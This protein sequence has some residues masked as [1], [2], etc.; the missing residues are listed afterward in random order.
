[1]EE[2][3]FVE[4]PQ[5]EYVEVEENFKVKD[6]NEVI[7]EL[8]VSAE[9][10][11]V[12]G[13]I[14]E[15][16]E[17]INQ[18]LKIGSLTAYVVLGQYYESK[19]E[20][21]KAQETYFQGYVANS[22]QCAYRISRMYAEGHGL[23]KSDEK[24]AFWRVKAAKLND[25][26]ALRELGYIKVKEKDY[27]SAFKYLEKASSL[28][29]CKSS[30]TLGMIYF[31]N[32]EQKNK[33]HYLTAEKFLFQARQNVLFKDDKK[34]IEQLIGDLYLAIYR[35]VKKRKEYI[36]RALYYLISA[37]KNGSKDALASINALGK[38]IE[39]SATL[40]AKIGEMSEPINPIKITNNENK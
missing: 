31:V 37:E 14:D 5:I 13:E 35:N 23:I 36:E 17:K 9:Q 10:N 24:V 4:K 22:G 2:V 12:V 3:E 25:L 28:G 27:K 21:E 38:E 40:L 26:D 32:G 16:M 29:D 7:K 8:L 18:A 1:M 11:F 19:K 15:G 34:R 33:K 39:I 30:L 20:F 6:R